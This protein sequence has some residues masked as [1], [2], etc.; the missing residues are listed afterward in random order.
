MDGDI[1]DRYAELIVSV[2]ANVQPDQVLA[3]EASPE[4]SGLVQLV[5]RKAYERGAR[6]VDVFYFDPVVKRIR[7]EAAPDGTLEWVPGWLGRR[8]LELGELDAA[9][10][11]LT[12]IFGPGGLEGIDP[13]RAAQ[14]RLPTVK[15]LFK[16]IEDKSVAWS[17]SPYP[18]RQWAA[19]VYPDLAPEEAVERL[20]QDV[21]HVCRLDEPDPAEAWNRRIDE[22]WQVA[23]RLDALDLDAVH[24]EGP[25]TDLTIGLLPSSRFAKEGGASHT[26]TGVRHVAN[27]PTEEVFTTPDPERVDGVVAA[28]KPLDVAGSVVRGLRVRFE[29][30]RAVQIDADENA[31]ALRARAAT[32]PGASRLGEVALVDGESRIGKLGTT[33]FNTLLDENAASHVALGDGYAAP[34]ADPADL[35]RINASDVH[36]DFMIGSNEVD[37]TGTTKSGE[38]VPLLRGGVWQI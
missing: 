37:V 14:D 6:Y 36:I 2:G 29:G 15:E 33:F 1:L 27:L 3:I 20:W 38:T 30:G 18:T 28:T 21:I 35:P 25:G 11:V 17:I 31:E 23:S 13:A 12:P 7:A 8:M 5:A 34:I 26:R 10:V 19:T 24:F 32:D 4:A 9:R 22:I 16:V